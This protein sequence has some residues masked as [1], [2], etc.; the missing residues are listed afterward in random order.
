MRVCGEC[1]RSS[2]QCLKFRN[3]S[4]LE[5]AQS[6]LV[7]LGVGDGSEVSFTFTAPVAPHVYNVHLKNLKTEGTAL[8]GCGNAEFRKP[9]PRRSKG[10]H[11]SV[12][13]VP[14]TR[15]ASRSE[16]FWKMQAAGAAD[17][18]APDPC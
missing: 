4:A 11:T 2:Q 13:A 16:M 12:P 1:K 14:S 5:K 3:V 17:H 7:F 9:V 6:P 8:P 15:L 10:V 18:T